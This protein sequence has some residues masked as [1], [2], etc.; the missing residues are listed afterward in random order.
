MKTK[1]NELISYYNILLLKKCLELL[2]IVTLGLNVVYV[3]LGKNCLS[4]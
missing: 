4:V 3:T 1:Y 2:E